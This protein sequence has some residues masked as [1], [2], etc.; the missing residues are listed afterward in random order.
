M[1]RYI[2]AN[3]EKDAYDLFAVEYEKDLKRKDEL[4]LESGFILFCEKFYG[5]EWEY[6][7][8]R[9]DIENSDFVFE[10]DFFEGQEVEYLYSIT[11]TEIKYYMIEK[12]KEKNK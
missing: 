12:F 5:E 1:P 3:K 10:Y 2:D 7:T 9:I 8:V 11:D 6:N 4:L